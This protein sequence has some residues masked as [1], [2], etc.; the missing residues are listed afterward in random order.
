MTV[1][2]D[3]MRAPVKRG[4]RT[5]LLCHMVADTESE[6][7]QMADRIG[8]E[9]R[10]HQHAGTPKSHYDIAQTKRAEAIAWGA[11]EV[12]Q[13]QLG[14]MVK[15]R[16]LTG[17]LGRPALFPEVVYRGAYPENRDYCRDFPGVYVSL[18]RGF[19]EQ[20]GE[21]V[22]AYRMMRR[23][24][25]LDL[26][27]GHDPAVRTVLASGEGLDPAT[28]T[29]EDLVTLAGDCFVQADGLEA[30]ARLDTGHDGFALGW[31]LFL[32]GRLSDWAAEIT[33]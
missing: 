28:L 4:F 22:R 31:D 6:L 30:L 27:A 11:L 32:L 17:R 20:W 29:E 7:H 23:P 25:L 26:A 18:Q 3:D 8:V 9:R 13:R 5:Y 12:T 33:P 15:H 19:A 24:R 1:Y 2:V 16:R 10:W 14:L 21:E